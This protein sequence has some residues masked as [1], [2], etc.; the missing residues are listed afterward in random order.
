DLQ[1]LL[2][3]GLIVKKEG[4]GY[5]DRFRDRVMFPIWNLS[6]RVVAFGGRKLS[7]QD[8]A[9]KYLNS[10]ETAVYEKGKLLYGLFQNRDEIRKL[11]QAIFV[12]G[13]TDLM[14][15]VSVGIKNVV[16]TLGTALTE[17]QARLVH[18]YTNDVV[19]MYD[20][21]T[22]GSAASLRGADV[23]LENGLNIFMANLPSG[24]DPDTFVREKGASEVRALVQEAQNLFDFKLEK[25]LAQPTEKR[26]ELIQSILESLA[27]YKD[28]IQRSLLLKK[29]SE[30]LEIDEKVLWGEMERFL[31]Q[32]RKS[33][34]RRSTIVDRLNALSKGKKVNKVERA[35]E[36]LAR[37]LIYEWSLADLIFEDLDLDEISEFKI[38]S[39]FNYLK[40]QFR[41]GKCP[42][43]S[44]LINNFNDVD[45]SAFIVN[46]LDSDF[47]SLDLERWATDCL[48][49]IK[50]ATLQAQ[51]E[52]VREHMRQAQKN[53]EPWRELLQ[54]CMELEQ[55]KK[56]LQDKSITAIDKIT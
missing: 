32:R 37:I 18:R 46:T 34:E 55:E 28:G 20:S 19:L 15:L 53:G 42:V 6:G 33:K 44:D 36:D 14:S 5:Y 35:A 17:H 3:A 8:D 54:V 1:W 50:H 40:N 26:S 27:R 31:Y 30:R 10:P 56:K 51:L 43:E 47:E 7:D 41:G 16:A 52:E 48:A 45:L 49:T 38:L 4:G 29:V 39:V 21:D 2:K 11:D 25:V 24:F 9:P 23:L 12:E 22:S 13:Y